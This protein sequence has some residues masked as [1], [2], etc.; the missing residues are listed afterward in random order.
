M[1]VSLKY[2]DIEEDRNIHLKQEEPYISVLSARRYKDEDRRRLELVL[3]YGAVLGRSASPSDQDGGDDKL[4]PPL[5]EDTTYGAAQEINNVYVSIQ[6]EKDAII[7]VPYEIR[8]PN[9]KDQQSKTLDFELRRN[10]DS[11]VVSLRLSLIHI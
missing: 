10:V 1:V 8:I 11:I 2:L 6:D 3:K 9:L 5:V 4:P 7:G